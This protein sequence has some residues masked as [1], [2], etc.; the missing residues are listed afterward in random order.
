MSTQQHQIQDLRIDP[1]ET[2][3]VNVVAKSAHTMVCRL[4]VR[5]PGASGWEIIKGPSGQDVFDVPHSQR[6][7]PCAEG[8]TVGHW[9]GIG[10]SP[11]TNFRA[12]ATYSQSG[13]VVVE[14]LFLHTGR[15]SGDTPIGTADRSGEGK[16]L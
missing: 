3:E 9:I 13:K 14:G 2:I 11:N 8:S 5:A 6:I 10:G 7:G 1:D 16:L 12:V 15:V 4:F